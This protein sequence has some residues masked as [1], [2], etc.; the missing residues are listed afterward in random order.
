MVV[1]GVVLRIMGIADTV[2]FVGT[3]V[4]IRQ[5]ALM[6]GEVCIC[7]FVESAPAVSTGGHAL[8]IGEED[9]V[10][11]VLDVAQL[12]PLVQTVGRGGIAG[13]VDGVGDFPAGLQLVFASVMDNTL[14]VDGGRRALPRLAVAE[15][16]G[17]MVHVVATEV[18]VAGLV[19]VRAE[20]AVE[21]VR[22]QQLGRADLLEVGR[23]GN[24]LRLFTGLRQRG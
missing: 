6:F 9:R 12:A 11:G 17:V 16:L 13:L 15:V 14:E 5:N 4:G 1:A 21:V 2:I 20:C 3:G 22:I 23:A 19:V 18:V 24:G 10:G 8:V 7:A